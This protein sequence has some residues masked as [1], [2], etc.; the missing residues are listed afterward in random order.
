MKHNCKVS[1][2]MPSL[3]VAK[4]IDQCI[5]SVVNQTLREIEIICID[6]GSTDGTL[7]IL[8]KYASHD[9]RIT[10]MN[11]EKRSYGY[12]M[13][14]GIEAA[15]G[16]YI[17][18]V[19]TDDIAE[20]HMFE[21]LYHAGED[22]KADY[23][24][25]N[26]LQF[27]EKEGKGKYTLPHIPYSGLKDCK[28]DYKETDPSKDSE[29]FVTDNFL[30]NG[31]YRS[32]FIK[33]IKFNETPGAAFQD[34]SVLFKICC[35][36]KEAIYVNKNVYLYRQDN[37]NAS[38]Y[39]KKSLVYTNG[40]Y[41]RIIKDFLYGVSE[42][43][44][45]ICYKKMVL[46]TLNRFD[47]MVSSANYWTESED[48]VLGI[49]EKLKYALKQ[50]IFSEK[51]FSESQWNRIQMFIDNPRKLFESDYEYHMKKVSYIHNL[52]EKIGDKQYIIFGFGNWGVYLDELF[53]LHYGIS[54][55][56]F[57]DNSSAKWG[58]NEKG[59]PVEKPDRVENRN[60]LF[61]ITNKMHSKEIREQ[62]LELGA[63]PEQMLD[64][65]VEWTDTRLYRSVE[66]FQ[67]LKNAQNN[68]TD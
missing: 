48:G 67:K 40:E 50:K 6:A 63:Y 43:W 62:L 42:D 47:E 27:Y 20:P 19:E 32:E 44:V 56:A 41:G 49:Q 16:E 5:S 37:L 21:V 11:S 25:G 39:N 10:I 65:T 36:A 59:V 2:I 34:I 26:A 38:S 66:C 51:D 7:E 52:R 28:A 29:I 1:V 45:K 64:F 54:P 58:R 3:N 4:Y 33:N 12:Q 14:L 15:K 53:H 22:K 24:K 18:I 8:E 23:I 68:L 55:K 60:T 30:W 13:N 31:I 46:L 9:D 17:G 35:T 57:W 61:I